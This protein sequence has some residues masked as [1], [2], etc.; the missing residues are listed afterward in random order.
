MFHNKRIL[1]LGVG[2]A[3]MAPLALWCSSQSTS[4]FGYDDFLKHETEDLLTQSGLTLLD[5]LLI[6]DLKSFDLV[7]YSNAFSL[8][9]PFLLEAKRLN[10]ECFRR[11]EFL[12]QIAQKKRLIVVVGSHGKTTT[13]ALIAFLIQ[14]YNQTID[15][16]L[17]GFLKDG[18]SP[19]FACGSDWLLA[20]ID[21]SDGSID[22]FS[23]ELTVFLNLSWDHSDYY[24]DFD[25]LKAVFAALLER[26]SGA[27]FVEKALLKTLGFSSSLFPRCQF[28]ECHISED[29]RES[30]HQN[31]KYNLFSSEFNQ[32]NQCFALALA[33]HLGFA[34]ESDR[35]IFHSFVGVKRRQNLLVSDSNLKV[36]LD[37]AHHP[38]EIEHLI[39]SVRRVYND[40]ELVLVFQPHRYSRMHSLK[41][42]LATALSEANR[43]FLLPIYSAFE[44]ELG[45][46]DLEEF[47]KL[48]GIHSSS[49]INLNISGLN[50]ILESI[51][52]S[53]KSVVLFVGAGSINEFSKAFTALYKEGTL[54]RAWLDFARASVS[55]DSVIK[56][57]ESLSEKTTFKI[58][59]SASFYA[60]PASVS[61]LL[62]LVEST[63]IFGLEYF[64]LGRGS[65][66]L[67]S[68]KG[69]SGLVLRL[70]QKRW[71]GIRAVGSNH[72]WVGSGVRLK[73]L[74]G[75]V[76]RLGF[77]GFEFLEGIPGTLGGALRMN[78]GAMGKWTFDV[79]ERVLML[80]TN[81]VIKSMPKHS[82]TIEYRRVKEISEGIA[83]GALLKLGTPKSTQT[84]RTK[85]DS[86]SDVRKGS[87]PI[88]PSAGCIF[89]NPNGNY[90][91]RLIDELGLKGA[92]FGK[93]EVSDV[94]G[95]FI[96]NKGGSSALEVQSLVRQIRQKVK[97]ESGYE[98]EPEVLLLGE[99][100][101]DVLQD[102]SNEKEL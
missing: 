93:A 72:L 74:C 2:G 89:K 101:D 39:Q 54:A 13:S 102:M 4:L 76:A 95:N 86:Y 73:E 17:G 82:F 92:S 34:Q 59:G 69:Y 97:N 80:D 26:T 46:V 81:G 38:F 99:N 98:L 57:D 48:V 87:Q 30:E 5:L 71:R 18:S 63:Q 56:L 85:I 37:Y 60:E 65:N 49:L 6:E 90:A 58:G 67:V 55:K 41:K 52:S 25:A 83:L 44:K 94:H 24:K 20:E 96:I 16:I 42:E 23:P 12:A 32:K 62:S 79:V 75:Y 3:G 36:Y 29:S 61:D 78:A 27:I 50:S 40:H 7:V 43:L 66:I 35:S 8:D 70:N 88:A 11:G 77:S 10:I 21:E 53:K 15:Y 91:G 68:D 31:F 9:N 45:E 1:F 100:W 22:Q 51:D 33:K 47:Q 28:I 19:A 64:C 14:K 84:I